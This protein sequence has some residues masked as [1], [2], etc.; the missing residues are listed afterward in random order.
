MRPQ[1]FAFPLFAAVAVARARR[2]A[3]AVAPRLRDAAAARAVDE[4]ARLGRCSARCS[5]RSPG[6]SAMVQQRR[7]SGRGLALLLAPW[8]CVFASPYAL[9][10]P[11]YYEKILVGGDF[12]Q[13]VTEWAPTTLTSQT[14]AVYLLV[15]GGLWLLGRAGRGAPAARPARIRIHRGARVRGGAEHRLDRA[16]G[17]RGAPAAR[18]PA[19]RAPAEEPSAP[20]PDP[21]GDDPRRA[22]S[23]RSPAS[24]RSRRAGSRAAFPTAA[25]Q[26]QRRRRRGRSGTGI[27]DRAPTPTGCCGAGPALAGRVAFDARFELLSPAQ[28]QRI[29]R[30]QARVGNWLTI[31]R[32]YR[33]FVLDRHSDARARA[34][35][36]SA[37]CRR[38]WSSARRRS[39]CYA[40]AAEAGT[41]DAARSAPRRPPQR[42]ARGR[43]ARS[44]RASCSTASA[45]AASGRNQSP[46]SRGR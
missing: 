30:F 25:A 40:G 14:A 27:R 45:T 39:W 24:R 41:S 2:R 42:R 21:C 10:L 16:R 1:S 13:F 29:A 11:A 7:A 38:G 28:V 9:H 44:P 5:S 22:S 3:A 20:E 46:D 35:L 15:L 8:A 31:A 18:R 37:T 12:K 19:A 26:G 6:S 17:A 32:G 4:P 34:A 43:S 33:V 23:S 36:S